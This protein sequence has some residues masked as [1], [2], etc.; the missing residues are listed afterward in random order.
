MVAAKFILGECDG[1]SCVKK[2]KGSYQ[3]H[4]NSGFFFLND[5]N[6]WGE[7]EHE[8]I[9]MLFFHADLSRVNKEIW[10]CDFDLGSD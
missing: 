10:S 3:R 2:K 8:F 7:K 1:S 4:I 9:F 5:S 6:L